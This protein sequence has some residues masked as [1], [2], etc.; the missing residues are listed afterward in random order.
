M[1][2]YAAFFLFCLLSFIAEIR[3]ED[4]QPYREIRYV[5]GTLLD[6]TLYHRDREEARK[7]LAEAFSVAQRLDDLLSN[8]KTESEISRLNQRAG[9]GRIKV[10]P[11]LYDFLALAM[12]LWRKTGGAF[13]ITV[14]PLM[15]LWKEAE[16]KGTLPSP[17]SLREALRLVGMRHVVLYGD[18]EVELARKGMAID[19]GGIGKGYAV[20]KIAALFRRAGIKRSLI[21]FGHSSIYALGIPPEANGWRVLLRFPGQEPL[22]I[23]ELKDQALSAS[24]TFGRPLEIGGRK[25]AHIVDPASGIAISQRIQAVVLGPSAAEAE[26]L[27]KYVIL[28][29][30]KREEATGWSQVQIL[31]IDETGKIL[32]SKNFP[33]KFQIGSEHFGW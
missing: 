18:F 32:R 25:Y 20:D 33:L 26:A 12:E 10:S 22:G 8:Y 27:T 28:K 5:M 23:L 14:G 30:S 7:S 11:E 29:G 9:A 1:R 2:L 6:I 15:K 19:T 4:L 13:D 31:R 17:S 24:D 16:E 21:N 3:A